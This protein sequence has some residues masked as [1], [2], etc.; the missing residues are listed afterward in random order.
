[1]PITCAPMI[2]KTLCPSWPWCHDDRSGEC[3]Q[4][5]HHREARLGGEQR[6]DHSGPAQQLGERGGRARLVPVERR[7]Q[8]GDPARVGPHGRHQRQPAEH[9]GAG[10][11]PERRERLAVQVAAGQQGAEDGRAEQGAEDGA[12]QHQRDPAGAAL[13][14]VHVAGR[15]AGE[16]RHAA[17]R[18]DPGQ[19]REHGGRRLGRAAQRR[20]R[21]AGRASQV[22]GRE[23]RHPPEAVHRP[24]GRQRGERARPEH[25]RR[26]KPEQA[27]DVEHEHQ[28]DRR[29]RGRQLEHRRVRRQRR[30]QQDGVAADRE[31]WRPAQES[32]RRNRK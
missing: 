24:A 6:R 3:H 9:D 7:D 21:A 12:E 25:D 19:P 14:R 20:E 16:Q 28:S 15:G 13:G 26:A 29:D 4:R 1:M 17:R 5:H 8:R 22:A 31:S 10:S 11:E 23:H 2:G 30:R 32:K 18:A 27:L